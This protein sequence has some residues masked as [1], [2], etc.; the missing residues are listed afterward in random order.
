MVRLDHI[1]QHQSG[2]SV[3]IIEL[4]QT[5]QA[6]MTLAGKHGQEAQERH[7]AQGRRRGTRDVLGHLQAHEGQGGIDAVHPAFAQLGR[8]AGPA[9]D[10]VADA[11]AR[12]VH[13]E[14]GGQR[15]Q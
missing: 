13:R 6:Q 10:G 12:E 2:A 5:L 11:R 3:G 15:Q 7:Q 14:L 9:A 1:S 4:Q 8:Q